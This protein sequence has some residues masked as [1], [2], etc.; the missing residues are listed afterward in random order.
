[1]FVKIPYRRTYRRNPDRDIVL[2]AVFNVP[3]KGKHKLKLEASK[4]TIGDAAKGTGKETTT[5]SQSIELEP[6]NAY[7][8]K[9]SSAGY[10]SKVKFSLTGHKDVLI[11]YPFGTMSEHIN[12]ISISRQNPV[13]ASPN[14]YLAYAS[15]PVQVRPLAALAFVSSNNAIKMKSKAL[16]VRLK[17][18]SD[19]PLMSLADDIYVVRELLDDLKSGNPTSFTFNPGGWYEFEKP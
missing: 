1:M 14:Q 7:Q 17:L 10:G 16:V 12:G 11:D 15:G 5:H 3:R 8:V 9:L 4:T 18:E 6:G 13:V 2:N 19:G